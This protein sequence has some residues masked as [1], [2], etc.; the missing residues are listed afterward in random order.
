MNFAKWMQTH[1]LQVYAGALIAMLVAKFFWS[2]FYY[3]MPLGYDVGIYRYLFAKHGQALPPF[4]L[5]N[6]DEWALGHSL[7]LFFFSSILV[8]VGVPVDWLIG[9]IWNAMPV[10]IL[11]SLAWVCSKQYGKEVGVLIL[12]VGLLSEPFY[13]GFSAMYW[14]TYAALLCCV[15]ALY[16]LEKNSLR[17]FIPIALAMVIHNQTGL[18]LGLV[19]VLWW[20]YKGVQNP[21]RE[22]WIFTGCAVASAIFVFLWY[23]P[24]WDFTVIDHL[25]TLLNKQGSDAP[26]GAFPPA[27]FYVRT[28]GLLIIAGVIGLV[29]NIHKKKGIGPWELA[30]LWSGSFVLFQLFFYRR[31]FLQ[32]DFF[33]M[34]FAAIGLHSI[35]TY[36]RD[37]I[38]RFVMG[39]L[40]LLQIF[41]SF[42]TMLERKPTIDSETF[43]LVREVAAASQEESSL[44]DFIALDNVSPLWF[45][46]W[47]PEAHVSGPG[48]FDF[49][50]NPQEWAQ[51]LYGSNE[52]RQQYFYQLHRRTFFIPTPL[53][54]EHY[55]DSVNG[56]LNDPCLYKVH[57]V[58]IIEILQTCNRRLP[59][60]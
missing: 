59:A 37:H 9:W 38:L 50:W 26:A 51:I 17:A 13:D 18:M 54:Y 3:E 31:F 27:L 48:L 42:R 8:H 7:G 45:Q 11:L 49:P 41:F 10:I 25:N 39:A 2:L 4:V 35:L 1:R 28:Q 6:V 32:F 60:S 34:P 29:L 24:V 22:W 14:K 36:R 46:G 15:F 12:L 58:P 30:A 23:L 20:L 52:L 40:L 33:L 44:Y 56:F 53:F 55:G 5:G 21:N 19:V 57:W 16:L 43:R 47:V